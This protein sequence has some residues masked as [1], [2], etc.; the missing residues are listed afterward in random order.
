MSWITVH[1]HPDSYMHKLTTVVHAYVRTP[2]T[3]T[4]IRTQRVRTPCTRTCIRTYTLALHSY[5]HT[6]IRTP[7]T[8]TP[9]DPAPVHDKLTGQS[10]AYVR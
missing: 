1:A 5:L 8:R 3:R 9:L 6:Y 7:W 2:C 4:C 10:Y